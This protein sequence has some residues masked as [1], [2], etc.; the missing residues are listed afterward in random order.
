MY[1]ECVSTVNGDRGF[2]RRLHVCA[3]RFAS[4][5][6]TWPSSGPPSLPGKT[7]YLSVHLSRRRGGRRSIDNDA[8]FSA[9]ATRLKSVHVGVT[10][11]GEEEGKELGH[12]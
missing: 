11:K 12:V 1:G 10:E 9:S 6:S 8:I 4:P 7:F 5:S 3:F 2:S